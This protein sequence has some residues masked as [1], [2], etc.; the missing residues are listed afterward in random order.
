M[1]SDHHRTKRTTLA[2]LPGARD[3]KGRICGSGRLLLT[4]EQEAII[5]DAWSRGVPSQQCAALARISVDR[6]R[7]RLTDQLADLPRRGRGGGSQ[8]RSETPGPEEIAAEAAM[9]R[10]GWPAER[11][12]GITAGTS[13][14]GDGDRDR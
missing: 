14:A 2:R 12:L 9:I 10:M 5:R 7:A 8:R 4:P 13:D 3:A 6:L 11:W 1:P